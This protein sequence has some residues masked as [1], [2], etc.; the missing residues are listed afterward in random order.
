MPHSEAE[1]AVFDGRRQVTDLSRSRRENGDTL[2]WMA[3]LKERF[4]PAAQELL[5]D[6]NL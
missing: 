3:P 2:H 1:I 5:N 6:I 4:T